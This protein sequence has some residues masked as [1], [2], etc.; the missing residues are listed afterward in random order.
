MIW[1]LF[2][3]EAPAACPTVCVII[4]EQVIIRLIPTPVPDP[5]V[6]TAII[7]AFLEYGLHVVDQTQVQ[8]I[9][10]S[11]D[12]WAS[13]AANGE[14]AAIAF[15]SERFAADIL[16]VGEAFAELD[17]Q[18]GDLVLQAA[19][20]RVELRA[21]E[22]A[23]GRILAAEAFHTGGID[24]TLETAAKRALQRGGERVAPLL[25]LALKEYLPVGCIRGKIVPE[26]KRIG[27][28]S[29][30]N[31][32]RRRSGTVTD[33]I[34]TMLETE[35]SQRR[36][37]T[38]HAMAVDIA[39]TGTITEWEEILTPAIEI[40][41]LDVLFRSGVAW[42]TVDVQVFDMVTAD[43]QAYEVTVRVTGIEIF[44]IRFG[45]STRS[46]VRKVC[47]GIADRISWCCRE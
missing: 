13:R 43:F 11:T 12:D 5:A 25:G 16:V 27:V 15:L 9:R 36:C 29:F 18:A 40:P 2:W 22:T 19:R 47:D 26:P 23:T 34:T 28:L 24:L 10:Y 20:A 30:V 41:V 4:P 17:E 3:A 35:L 46:L 45:M 39:V 7:H 21:I 14:A 37:P 32:S 1:L 8:L 42:M 38:A 33:L 44:G 31:Q 6:E